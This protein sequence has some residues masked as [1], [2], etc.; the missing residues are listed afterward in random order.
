MIT[1]FE[2]KF[3]SCFI[4]RVIYNS[5]IPKDGGKTDTA[6]GVQ[7]LGLVL[8]NKLHPISPGTDVEEGR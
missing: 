5:M 3:L 7:L 2:I 4:F 6:I 8:A 1:N